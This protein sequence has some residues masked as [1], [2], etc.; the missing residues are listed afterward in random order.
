LDRHAYVRDDC[1]DAWNLGDTVDGR[2]R[3]G[4]ALDQRFLV[5]A[6]LFTRV[7]H[8]VH[9]LAAGYQCIRSGEPFGRRSGPQSR[10]EESTTS[11]EHSSTQEERDER[12]K[13]P[14][15]AATERLQRQLQ[16]QAALRNWAITSTT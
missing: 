13:R 1:R 3:D 5:H 10:L 7:D 2:G 11:A 12:S 14:P 4:D 8:E 15:F 6:G 9:A 16:H